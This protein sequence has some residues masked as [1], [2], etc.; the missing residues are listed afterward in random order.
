ML[1]VLTSKKEKDEK[2]PGTAVTTA[3]VGGRST[4]EVSYSDGDWGVGGRA[5]PPCL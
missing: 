4:Q 5:P 2:S 1:L 3:E